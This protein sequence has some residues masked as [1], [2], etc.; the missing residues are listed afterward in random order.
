VYDSLGQTT[1]NLKKISVNGDDE[2][3]R[4]RVK[5]GLLWRKSILISV[6]NATV[7]EKRKAI[8]L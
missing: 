5:T 6:E 1:R 2:P 8:L 7:D 3:A 4:V